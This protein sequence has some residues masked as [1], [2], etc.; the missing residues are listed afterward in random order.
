MQITSLKRITFLG[1]SA[2]LVATGS[3][4]L[5][6][7]FYGL[8]QDIRPKALANADLRFTNVNNLSFRDALVSSSKRTN[9]STREYAQRLSVVISKSLSHIKWNEEKDS[10]RFN[11]LIPIW[12]NYF[13]YAMGVLTNI[14]EYK[15]YHFSNYK[16]SLERGIGICGDASMIMSQLLTKH[17]INNQIISFP[18]HVLVEVE[19]ADGKEE[20]YD[21]D[22]GLHLPLSIIEINKDTASAA[23][24]YAAFGY[25]DSDVNY[26]TQEF[27][28][29]Y[30]RWDGV[31]H[32]IT[33]KY[34]FEKLVYFLKWPFPVILIALGGVVF[35]IGAKLSDTTLTVGNIGNSVDSL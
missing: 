13:L 3:L 19:H 1:I 17:G 30:Q 31:E 22:F 7:N 2:F 12:E 26:F 33:K 10:R 9:E 34:Y 16:R 25:P 24:I 20:T 11:Q 14:P 21:P 27:L 29:K 15:K 5:S 8:T 35:S 4:L 32:F 6:I 18:G 23:K 28:K